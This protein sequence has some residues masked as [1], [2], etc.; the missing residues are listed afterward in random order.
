LRVLAKD[1]LSI[2]QFYF[3]QSEPFGFEDCG[4]VCHSTK[5][6]LLMIVDL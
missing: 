6:Y 2:C 3:S 4:R 1:R 5:T